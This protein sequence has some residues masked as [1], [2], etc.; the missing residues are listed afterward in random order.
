MNKRAHNNQGFTIIELVLVILLV[1]VLAVIVAAS[2]NSVRTR[3]RNTERRN[4]ITIIQGKLEVYYAKFSQYPTLEE[5]NN[6]KWRGENLKDF[7][8]NQLADPLNPDT[9][10]LADKPTK[11]QYSYEV[12]STDG[13]DCD[14]TDTPCT[15]YTLT[16]NYDGGGTFSKTNIN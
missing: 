9:K 5:I 1:L 7:D 10:T 13:K 4:E 14:N 15:Q 3:E 6:D 2:Y 16:T 11:H 12:S 8:T